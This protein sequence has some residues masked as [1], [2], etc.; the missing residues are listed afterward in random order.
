MIANADQPI[1]TKVALINLPHTEALVRRYMCTYNS[2]FFFPPLELLQAA[3]CIRKGTG[4]SIL[5][6]DAIAEKMNE[7]QVS[8][9]LAAEQPDVLIALLGVESVSTDYACAIHLARTV[10][11]MQLGLFGYYATRFPEELLQ[12]PEVDVVFRGDVEESC[13]PYVLALAQGHCPENIPGLAGRNKDSQIFINEPAYIHSFEHI[14]FPDY[15]LINRK[16][17]QEG[18]MHGTFATLQI[19]RGCPF[20]CAYCT[21][22]QDQRYVT[23]SEEQVVQELQELADLGVKVLRFLDD[24]F[25]VNRQRVIRICKG[26]IDKKIK[27][28]WSCLSRVDTLE[29]EMLSWMRKAGCVRVIVGVESYSKHVLE[30]YGKGVDPQSI[31]KQLQL[32][33]DAGIESFGFIIVG[34]PFESEADFEVTKRGVL[35]SSLDMIAVSSIAIYGGSVMAERFRDEI[36]F[37]LIPYV[38]RWRDPAIEKTALARERSLYR[39]FYCRPFT[40]LKLL[41]TMLLHPWMSLKLSLRFLHFQFLSLR[42]RERP[43]LF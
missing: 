9:V 22:Q 4:A 11:H 1:R 27:L 30:N 3:S 15:S 33:R 7:A 34:G 2:P 23:R 14:P 16:K 37:Q 40:A 28:K 25:T 13:V 41:R 29:A 31:N 8:R 10:P 19:S 26:I 43:D 24:T 32:I 42:S 39:A 18:F 38:S 6:I 17:Y 12:A 21:S 35:A 20:T 5:F 36:E